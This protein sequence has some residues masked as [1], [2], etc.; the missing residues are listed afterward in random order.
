MGLALRLDEDM[1]LIE[2]LLRAL[3][4]AYVD[5][6][7]FFRTLSHY[8]GERTPLFDIAMN[9]VAID[10]WLNLYDIRLSKETSTQTKRQE[11]MIKTNPKYVLKNYMLEEAINLAKRG[12]FSMVETLLYLATNPFEEL[13][14][15]EHFAK[16]TPEEYK[17]IT[18]SC[19]S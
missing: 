3:Q 9:P 19:S 13:P 11:I 5:Y 7:I 12:D 16:E 8:D 1:S 17:N 10:N 15:F 2:N 4:D 6:T 14:E 18:L